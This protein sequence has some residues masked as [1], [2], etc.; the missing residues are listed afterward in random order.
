VR[1]LFMLLAVFAGAALPIQASINAEFA[2]R[3]ATVFWAAAISAL[4]TAITLA[5][6]A[7]I[8]LRIP[9]PSLRLFTEIPPWLWWGGF[10]GVVVLGAMSSVPQRIGAATMIVCFV[11]GQTICSLVL[12]HFGALGLPQQDLTAGRILGAALIIAGVM[13]VRFL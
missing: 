4:L 13:L 3:G 11:A 9:P 1:T 8:F 12:D 10:L 5:V 7:V 6:V 2:Q